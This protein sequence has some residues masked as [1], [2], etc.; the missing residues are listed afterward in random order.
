VR[1]NVPALSH[2]GP[3]SAVVEQIHRVGRIGTRLRAHSLTRVTFAAGSDSTVHVHRRAREV[4]RSGG[5]GAVCLD[6]DDTLVDHAGAARAALRRILDGGPPDAWPL[7]KAVTD[8]H[9]TRVVA[10]H[11][12]SDTMRWQRTQDFFACL[13][14]NIDNAEAQRRERIREEAQRTGWR[15]FD[16]TLPCLDWLRAAGLH[17]AVVTNASGP[18][19]RAKLA[20]LG[21]AGYLDAVV[22]A[23]E[24]GAAKPDPVIFHTACAAVGHPPEQVAH[25][26]DRLDLDAIGARDAGLAGVWLNR[27]GPTQGALPAGIRMISSLAT[28]P[29]LLVCELDAAVR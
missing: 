12:D 14:E 17:I 7:W 15:L 13:G 9:V 21:V 10:G 2:K 3:G 23:G 20:N 19:Q 6:V 27:G 28:L 24:L 11:V 26:G 1:Q 25:I 8:E 5:V 22:I 16:D 4:I 29:E 18:Y